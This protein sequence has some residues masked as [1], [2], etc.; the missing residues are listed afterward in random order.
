MRSDAKN[1]ARPRDRKYRRRGGGIS[2]ISNKLDAGPWEEGVLDSVERVYMNGNWALDQ[3]WSRSKK[4]RRR[5][6]VSFKKD[7][8]GN[9]PSYH[10]R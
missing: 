8:E 9:P 2:S 7:D 3:E 10:K 5:D 4:E 1:G 6:K